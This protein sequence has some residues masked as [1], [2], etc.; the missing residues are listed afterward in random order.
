MRETPLGRHLLQQPRR[1]VLF[2]REVR[3]SVPFG[4][5]LR[6]LRPLPKGNKYSP[7]DIRGKPSQYS[8]N[9]QQLLS[10]APRS[11]HRGNPQSLTRGGARKL[12]KDEKRSGETERIAVLLNIR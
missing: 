10:D 11:P 7:T 5:S 6:E 2:H 8:H 9:Y 4:D 1:A 12:S 3:G